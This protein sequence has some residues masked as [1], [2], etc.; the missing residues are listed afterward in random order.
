MTF[1]CSKF[2]LNMRNLVNFSV[3]N[4]NY[5][6]DVFG[7]NNSYANNSEVLVTVNTAKLEEG[8]VQ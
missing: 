7:E 2:K 1:K 4:N 8:D 5:S 6:Q 3:A